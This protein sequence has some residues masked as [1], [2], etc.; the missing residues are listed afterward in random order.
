MEFI[1]L[2]DAQCEEIEA[3]LES[4]DDQHMPERPEGEI[5]IGIVENGELIAGA[6]ACM[7]AFHI[8]YVST[9]FVQEE[10]RRRG[11]GRKLMAEVEARAKKMGADTIRLDTFSWQGKEF[12]QV[13]GY[14]IVGQYANAKD[15]YEEFFF[16][17]RV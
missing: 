3:G 17:K 7:T 14:E 5:S 15:G 9:V 13:L 12:Y 11:V 1:E 10:Y 2:N 16:L 4:Y 8:C 6:D